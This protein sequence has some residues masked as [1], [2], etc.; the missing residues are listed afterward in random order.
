MMKFFFLFH[1]TLIYSS[2]TFAQVITVNEGLELGQFLASNKNKDSFLELK[3]NGS[4][5]SQNLHIT[6]PPKPAIISVSKLEP[7]KVYKVGVEKVDVFLEDGRYTKKAALFSILDVYVVNE[8][9]ADKHGNASFSVGFKML[10]KSNQIAF[11]NQSF[12]TKMIV[13]VKP[14]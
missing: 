14:E 10:L 12:T 11:S 9:V 8:I 4:Y 1:S 3:E 7:F 13:S 5:K 6:S 2:Q